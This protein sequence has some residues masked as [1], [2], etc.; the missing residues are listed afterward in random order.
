MAAKSAATSA[1]AILI[2]MPLMTFAVAGILLGV[3][4]ITGGS[5]SYKQVLAVYVHSG[6]IGTVC[7]R[8]QRP[9]QLLHGE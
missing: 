8:H 9:D 1:D 6:V 2:F 7:R 4:A 3:F 5:A